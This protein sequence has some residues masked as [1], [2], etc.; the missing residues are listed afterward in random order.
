MKLSKL[1]NGRCGKITKINTQCPKLKKRLLELGVRK[2]Q[3]I[4]KE[5]SAPLGDPIQYKINEYNILIR[6]LEAEDIEI[7]TLEE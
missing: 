7:N 5:R 4:R 6:K 3:I 2:N 1:C